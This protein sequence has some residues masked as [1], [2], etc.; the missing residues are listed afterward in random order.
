MLDAISVYFHHS[1]PGLGPEVEIYQNPEWGNR[2]R[3][4]AIRGM[5]YF[6]E[7]L[8]SRLFVAGQSFSM[9]DITLLAGP[10]FARVV[11]L[12]IPD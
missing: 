9:A 2:Q 5:R 1:T 3:E 6:D 7:V 10:I 12:D 4:K 8:R 11:K